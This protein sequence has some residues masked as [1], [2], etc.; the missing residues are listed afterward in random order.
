[1]TK[2]ADNKVDIP[3]DFSDEELLILFKQAHAADLTFNQF[4]EQALVNF[5]ERHK[6]DLLQN[7]LDGSSEH[8]LV[9]RSWPYPS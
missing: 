7:Q 1:M 9:P 5:L 4:I 8:G 2:L 6:N 3:L